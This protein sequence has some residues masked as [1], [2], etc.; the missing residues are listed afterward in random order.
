MRSHSFYTYLLFSGPSCQHIISSHRIL[1][2][3]SD[4]GWIYMGKVG[5][6]VLSIAASAILIGFL[7]KK[8]VFWRNTIWNTVTYEPLDG[9]NVRIV[10]NLNS[11]CKN[12]SILVFLPFNNCLINCNSWGA[13]D[14]RPGLQETKHS[15]FFVFAM[16]KNCSKVSKKW[17][18]FDFF[19]QKNWQ[20]NWTNFFNFGAILAHFAYSFFLLIFFEYETI[21][22]FVRMSFRCAPLVK[23]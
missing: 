16:L 2:N 15:W 4:N 10:W 12:D 8:R 17:V 6:I 5:A 1:D 3:P 20:Q 14:I 22:T 11:I 9:R 21:L 7:M 18:K 23:T 13:F 19:P